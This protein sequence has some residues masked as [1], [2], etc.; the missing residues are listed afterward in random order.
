MIY[1]IN[2]DSVTPS[3]NFRKYRRFPF[4]LSEMSAINLKL[5]ISVFLTKK[6]QKLR[7]SVFR[8]SIHDENIK[9]ILEEKASKEFSDLFVGTLSNRDEFISQI[10][11]SIKKVDKF[12][13]EY[14]S[15]C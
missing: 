15:S 11:N 9:F 12:V 3:F 4:E 1:F 8:L 14:I 2:I 13:E 6:C 7:L 10:L 5:N